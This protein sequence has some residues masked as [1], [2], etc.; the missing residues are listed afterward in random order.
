[1]NKMIYDTSEFFDKYSKY[2][3][4]YKWTL[5]NSGRIRTKKDNLCPLN[6]ICKN[7]YKLNIDNDNTLKLQKT[8]N[9]SGRFAI[10][11]IFGSDKIDCYKSTNLTTRI[12]NKL[13]ELCELSD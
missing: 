12:R 10:N 2:I 3:K 13:L 4:K 6:C 11:F 1:M 9:L 8:L 7:K 5:D